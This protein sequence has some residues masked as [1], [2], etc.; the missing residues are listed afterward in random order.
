MV[1][2]TTSTKSLERYYFPLVTA[3]SLDNGSTM[4]YSKIT[5]FSAAEDTK[6]TCIY[7]RLF[8]VKS[9]AAVDASDV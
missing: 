8:R 5:E 1:I 6:R 2:A 4:A 9:E 3:V 7:E